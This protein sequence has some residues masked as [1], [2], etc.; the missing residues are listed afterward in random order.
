MLLQTV[1]LSFK[2]YY[3]LSFIKSFII[4]P[5]N[6]AKFRFP[7]V[8]VSQSFPP[9]PKRPGLII[10]GLSLC[11]RY[12]YGLYSFGLEETNFYR[13]AEIQAR[14]VGRFSEAL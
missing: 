2:N 6:H 14:K 10:W 4:K 13:E 3:E 12:L 7:D 5:L 8:N 9:H 1:D 11:T